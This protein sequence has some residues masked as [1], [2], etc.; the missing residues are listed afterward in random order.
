[1]GLGPASLVICKSL[2]QVQA[3]ICLPEAEALGWWKG[4]GEAGSCSVPS[5]TVISFLPICLSGTGEKPQSHLGICSHSR[6]AAAAGSAVTQ[7]MKRTGG[8]AGY[9]GEVQLVSAQTGTCSGYSVAR[10]GFMG[11]CCLSSTCGQVGMS[12]T[13]PQQCLFFRT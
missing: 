1:M 13:T 10:E 11:P 2:L 4:E 6:Y 7:Q 9:M 8:L 12:R 3:D 5:C